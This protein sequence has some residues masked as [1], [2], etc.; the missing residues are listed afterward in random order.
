MRTSIFNKDKFTDPIVA[1]KLHLLV[2]ILILILMAGLFV[3]FFW[4]LAQPKADFYNELWGP[5]YLMVHGESPYNTASLDP[6]LPAAWFPMAIGFFGPLGWIS[7]DI[8]LL[9]WFL[10]CTTELFVIVFLS[11]GKFRAFYV[12]LIAALL[13][14]AFPPT[15]YHFFLGQ[16]TLTVTL[17]MI[18]ATYSAI[19]GKHWLAAFLV[20]LG[21]SKPHLGVLAVL[22]LSVHYF[23][24]GGIRETA[25]FYLRVVLMIIILCLPL[26]FAYPNWIPDAV[27]SMQSNAYWVYPSLHVLLQRNLGLLGIFIW[28]LITLSILLLSYFLWRKL[29]PVTAMFWSLGLALLVTPYVGSWDFVILLP[30][31]IA[32]FS[33]ADWK[34]K[35]FLVLS[36]LLAW[37]GM[38]IIQ[39]MEPSHN[40][41]F[42]WVPPWF[43]ASVAIVTP[44]K[45]YVKGKIKAS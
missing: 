4:P 7:E 20:A 41:Y 3:Y 21:L 43:L 45:E 6:V 34:R 9:V 38:A 22:G 31:L 25:A 27:T 19:K 36:Y 30:I 39:R 35:L 14:F 29:Q 1:N 5:A 40:Y 44:W 28:G 13:A 33:Q 24:G 12:T 2:S 8:A 18:L 26:F 17:C 10:F 16:I 23:R 32:T 11:Q 15:L 37:Y 42:W